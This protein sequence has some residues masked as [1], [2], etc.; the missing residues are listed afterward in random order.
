ML[1]YCVPPALW[2]LYWFFAKKPYE[3]YLRLMVPF[4]LISDDIYEI[5]KIRGGFVAYFVMLLTLAVNFLAW[6]IIYFLPG[7]KV[8]L[9]N[10]SHITLDEFICQW[11]WI[12]MVTFLL[13][14]VR[15]P[16]VSLRRT[17]KLFSEMSQSYSEYRRSVPRNLVNFNAVFYRIR[18]LD[19]NWGLIKTFALSFGTHF[20]L[21]VVFIYFLLSSEWFFG[22]AFHIPILLMVVVWVAMAIA[23]ILSGELYLADKSKDGNSCLLSNQDD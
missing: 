11:V 4:Y 20:L 9:E 5:K 14:F 17:R 12:L 8:F 21:R 6:W 16:P 7:W 3:I 19:G 22:G 18:I 1:R 13:G 10:R 23:E 2:S 15:V